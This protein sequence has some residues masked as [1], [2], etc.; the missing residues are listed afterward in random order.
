[1]TGKKLLTI[2]IGDSLIKVCEISKRNKKGAVCLHKGFFLPTPRGAASD[3]QISHP[4]AIAELLKPALAAHG[5]KQ[6]TVAFSLLSGKVATRDVQM[7]P[8]K[9]ARIK[10]V[11][12]MNAVEYF[13]VDVSKYQFSHALV[14]T[15]QKGE[16][17]H[18]QVLVMAA[19]KSLLEGYFR[20]AELLD[21]E[22][23]IIDYSG[24]SIFRAL[25]HLPDRDVTVYV[26]MDA[27][28]SI[29]TVMDQG[30]L[31]MQR[32]SSCGGDELA[33]GYLSATR[34]DDTEYLNAYEELYGPQSEEN[35]ALMDEADITDCLSRVVSN[36]ARTVDYYNS[37]NWERQAEK[38]VI[39]GLCAGLHGLAQRIE[40]AVN[41]PTTALTAL[42]DVDTKDGI[43]GGPAAYLH[44]M[45]SVLAPV[46]FVPEDMKKKG[47]K[48][49]A[50][51]SYRAGI[52][53]IAAAGVL[54]LALS[55]S[56]LL[57]WMNAQQD[58]ELLDQKIEKLEHAEAVYLEYA[59]HRGALEGWEDFAAMAD[60]PNQYLADFIRELE[61]K[62]PTDIRLLSAVCTA[63][64][65]NMNV[66][67]DSKPSAAEVIIQLRSFDS[68]GAV[69]VT[70]ITENIDETGRNI[71]AFGVSCTYAAALAPEEEPAAADELTEDV[72]ALQ[73]QEEEGE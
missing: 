67:V 28:T 66:T 35:L 17:A 36:A 48:Q 64:N 18:N 56:A 68:L 58:L 40:E 61:E 6:K 16:D 37:S 32:F 14:H 9:E 52:L 47:Q 72:E 65:V 15:V 70:G 57:G 19:P 29:I 4:E 53:A 55:A 33:L 26:D 7:P 50:D 3:G 8:V 12:E 34:R 30:R 27:A 44:C 22:I 69:D 63:T 39:T 51:K 2:E 42:P 13:P 60:T 31:V 38:V 43:E 23:Q 73:E 41:L 1:M 5:M 21:L 49:S 46:D 25:E 10:A 62:M 45:G 54:G 59:A 71:V 24:N 11:V 20:L